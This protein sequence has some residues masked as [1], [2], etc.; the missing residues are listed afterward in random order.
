MRS[1]R[2]FA[3]STAAAFT[4]A[5][6]APAGDA[7]AAP[8]DF[9]IDGSHSHIVFLVNHLGYSNNVGRFR[10]FSGEFTLDEDAPEDSSV[11]V[12]I[13]SDSV[14]TDHEARDEHLRSPDFLN[15]EEFPTITFESTSVEMT[16]D[17]TAEV[18]GDFT[19]L[20]QT[21]P[22]TLDVTFNRVAPHPLPQY[23]GVLTAGLSARGT[24]QRSQWGMDTFV[25][26]VGDELELIIEIEGADASASE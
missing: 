5:A 2:L 10:D 15:A 23:D 17:K 11:S 3:L 13:Q 25:P 6:L 9:V 12:T 18:T 1:I 26:A 8:Q 21:H 20:G 24:L 4:F 22:V 16:G 14:F 19:M 7:Q